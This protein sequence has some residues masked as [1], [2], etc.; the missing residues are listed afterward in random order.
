MEFNVLARTELVLKHCWG[1]SLKLG[2]YQSKSGKEPP[3][4]STG[5]GKKAEGGGNVVMDLLC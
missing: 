4:Q 3:W 5:E 1:G 2:P